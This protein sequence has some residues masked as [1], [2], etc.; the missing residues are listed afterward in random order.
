MS[1]RYDSWWSNCDKKLDCI[2]LFI[3][4]KGL[5]SC[6]EWRRSFNKD[7]RTIDYTTGVRIMDNAIE[8]Q[9]GVSYMCTVSLSGH[10]MHSPSLTYITCYHLWTILE[11]CNSRWGNP[12]PV[13]MPSLQVEGLVLASSTQVIIH[14]LNWAL[15]VGSQKDAKSQKGE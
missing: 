8:M 12:K 15:L 11:T 4:W 1:L 14:P 5:S 2:V 7:F 3:V 9:L 10:L 6:F 13:A